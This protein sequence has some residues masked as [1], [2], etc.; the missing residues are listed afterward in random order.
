M[1]SNSSPPSP[2][3]PPAELLQARDP[4]ARRLGVQELARS[5]QKEGDPPKM[6]LNALADDNWRVRKE[7]ASLAPRIEDRDALVALLL[8]ALDQKENIGLRNAAVE[9][10]V[11][12]GPDAVTP[13]AGALARLDADGRKLVVEALGGIPDSRGVA[14]LAGALGDEDPNVRATAAE[15]L[16]K[17]GL[18]GEEARAQACAALAA[19]LSR[20]EPLLTA[21][22]LEALGRL[23]ARLPWSTYEPFVRDP[24]LKRHAIVAAAR[25][26]EAEALVA[27]ARAVGDASAT[28]AREALVAL[29]SWL[30]FEP[31]A[32]DCLDRAR[33]AL[34]AEPRAASFVRSLSAPSERGAGTEPADVPGHAAALLALGLLRD[35]ADLPRLVA[36]LAE[37]DMAEHAAAALELYGRAAA[38]PLTDMLP[39]LTEH[40]RAVILS[41]LPRLDPEPPAPVLTMLREGLDDPTTDLALAS[42]KGLA[43]AGDESDLGR[44][45]PL[46][47]ASGVDA[48]LDHAAQSALRELTARHPA[49]ALALLRGLSPDGEHAVA[50]CAMAGALGDPANLDFVVRALAH[51]EARARKAAV[52]ALADIGEK[53]DAERERV[54]QQAAFA[55]TDEERDVRLAAV[56]TL[57]RLGHTEP[58]A[59]L[60]RATSDTSSSS[61][62][63]APPGGPPLAI[64]DDQDVIVAAL[65]ALTDA[66]PALAVEAARPLVRKNDPAVACA[67]VEAIGR[68]EAP[69][70]DDVLF[71]AL[72]HPDAEVVK[73]AV[74]ELGRRPDARALARLG[75][76]LDHPSWEVRRL[77]SELLGQSKSSP[78]A[79]ELLRARLERE[80]EPVV[81]EAL[82]AAL[83]L[84]PPPGLDG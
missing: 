45:V 35:R 77:A 71:E 57:G 24:L 76:C 31:L 61:S 84:R 62:S 25:S 9:A 36:A 42:M 83:S 70:R 11:A 41:L 79:R 5:Q 58:L 19:V 60:L 63:S 46:A 16:G 49:A 8:G 3:P 47:N 12:L 40:T 73:L 50:G 38:E 32:D 20:N 10:L 2:T 29:G 55:L 72:E 75:T 22:A 53:A 78:G 34:A 51:V 74:T 27:L 59:L 48:R 37:D 68:A 81:R 28:V 69:A 14:A 23:D 33:T 56:R 66:D 7:A 44:L 4:E 15:A 64:A 39:S 17:A 30:L 6:L 65:R 54:R 82:T 18:A 52:E 67:V 26:R 43:L 80:R 1:S 13:L 21:A